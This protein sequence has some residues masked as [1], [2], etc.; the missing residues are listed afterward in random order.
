MP[1]DHRPIALI[2]L[3]DGA[4]IARLG[5]DDLLL[6]LG[7]PQAL[8]VSMAVEIDPGIAAATQRALG[9]AACEG[10]TRLPHHLLARN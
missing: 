1:V 7:M 6:H 2:S 9:P 10:T 4:G 5:M 3:F 8:V